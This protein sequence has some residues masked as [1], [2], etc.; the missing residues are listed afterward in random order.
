[1]KGY[2]QNSPIKNIWFNRNYNIF[3]KVCMNTSSMC[4]PNDLNTCPM[5]DLE[6]CF[7]GYEYI[8]CEHVRLFEGQNTGFNNQN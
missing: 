1:M 5:F 7:V 2:L 8:F 6:D 4:A 3:S